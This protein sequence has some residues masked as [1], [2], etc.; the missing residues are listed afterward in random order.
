[1]LSLK[2]ARQISGKRVRISI[3]TEL[4]AENAESAEIQINFRDALCELCGKKQLFDDLERRSLIM[5]SG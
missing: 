1:M 2:G 4:T 5:T 3:R